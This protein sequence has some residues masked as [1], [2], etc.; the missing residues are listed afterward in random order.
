MCG[1]VGYNGRQQAAKYLVDG[2][3]ALEYRGYDS[4]GVEILSPDGGLHG[5][6][7]AG[8]V[9]VLQE[10]V[11]TANLLGTCGIAHTRW[12]THGAPSDKNAHPHLDCSGRVA[13][14]HNGIIENYRQLRE[15]LMAAGHT[16]ASDTD[17]EVVAHL[18]EDSLAG[19]AKG[20]LLEAVRI[21]VSR[22]EGS[23]AICAMSADVPGVLVCARNRSPLVLASTP[24]G[25]FCASDVTALAGKAK[26]V[27]QLDDGQLAQ[28][29]NDGTI[30]VVDSDGDL[31]SRPSV[32]AV[33]W[34]ASAATL[35]GYP[36]FMAK[37]IAEQPEAIERLLA[38]RLGDN[39]IRL[40]ELALSH[41]EVAAIDRIYV[42]A[43]G[44]SYHVG[45][46]ARTLIEAWAHVPVIVETASEFNYRDVLVTDHTLCVVIS[47]SGETADTLAS[48]R[49]MRAAGAN[50]FA[51]T[52]V[53][54]STAARESDGVLYIQAGP[55]VCVCSTKAYT[56]QMVAAVLLTLFLAQH[57]GS[58]SASEVAA[59]FEELA[60]VPDQIRE[61]LKRNWQDRVAAQD[62]AGCHSSLFLGRG[63]NATTAAEGALKL[64]EISYL[65]AEAYAA[66]EMKHGPIALL[67]KGFPVVVV[68]PKDRV[69]DK[70][71]SNIEE[72]I[73]RGATCVAVATDGD[74]DVAALCDKILWI[75]EIKEEFFVPIVAVVHLQLLSR[76]VALDRDCD[77]DKPRNLAKSVTVE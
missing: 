60:K 55:E 75:P 73:A 4:A 11:E 9:A 15:Q 58:M 10:R 6:K 29:S 35:G 40:D 19:P 36:D 14:V 32:F 21:A 72:V 71:V 51:I 8:R 31:V 39:G 18:V 13:I 33:D 52:N 53:I 2:L 56:A 5:V 46:I 63:V 57:N 41:D 34:D 16:F 25:S 26:Q 12:A 22:L 38:D 24:D 66:G 37:E 76:Y 54:G 62:F 44:T 48:A 64:K 70:T 1:I 27:I 43:C 20:D 59:K 30:K 50:V 67:E 28:L 3:F 23:W 77:V 47:Q 45:L 68:V 7:C 74:V 69:H 61:V 42:V 17:S 65:H 49:K